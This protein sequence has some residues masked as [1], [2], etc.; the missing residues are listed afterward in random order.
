MKTKN[1][2]IKTAAE[3]TGKKDSRQAR[4]KKTEYV[5]FHPLGKHA[6]AALYYGF[7]PS[8]IIEIK[9]D[10]I[11]KINA[12]KD[13]GYKGGHWLFGKEFAEER[14]ALI[15]EYYEKN[16]LSLPQPVMIVHESESVKERAKHTINLEIIGTNRSIAEALLIKTALSILKDNGHENFVIEINSIGDKESM[17]RFSKELV[18]YYKKNLNTLGAHCRQNFKKDPFYLLSCNECDDGGKLKEGAPTSIASLS[19]ESRIH[20]KEVLEYIETMDI[21]YKINNFLVPDRKVCSGTVFEIKELN[22]KG[23]AGEV[24]AVG[25]R[26]DGLAQ[27]VGQKRDI[28]GAGLKI[29]PHKKAVVKKVEKLEKPIAFYIQLGDEA[30]HK[31]L[32]VIEILK[33]SKIFIYHMLGRDKFGSQFSLVEKT[34]VPYVIIMGKKEFLEN[35]VMVR[36]NST[37]TQQTILI[38]NLVAYLRSLPII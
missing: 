21:P 27:K 32:E 35:S 5:T 2:K 12:I 19:D 7:T 38:E 24:L 16:M 9:K 17:N 34:K 11:S 18:N 26:F 8:K 37:R 36:E 10:D 28:P 3:K 31:S 6:E 13:S 22:E 29:F 25:F 15:R 4:V 30:K 14:A 1:K 23:E 33:D 20:F